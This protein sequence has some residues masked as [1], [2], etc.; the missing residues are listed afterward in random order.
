MTLI[1]PANSSTGVPTNTVVRVKF[2]K[3]IAVTSA[4][5]EVF[6]SSAGSI[7]LPGTLTVS[8]D[9]SSIAFTLAAPLKQAST[10]YGVFL[11][12]ITDVTG[13]AVTSTTY[14]TFTTGPGPQTN[15]PTVVAVT[16]PNGTAGVRR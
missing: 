4:N 8:P 12:G 14:S 10:Q 11:T 13:A 1:D 15:A 6:P 7:I 2:N 3:Q 9:G 5:V 16:P